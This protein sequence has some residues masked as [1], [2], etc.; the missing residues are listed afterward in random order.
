MKNLFT[1]TDNN[2]EYIL[3]KYHNNQIIYDFKNTLDFLE[4]KGKQLFGDN[5]KIYKDDHP[6]IYKLMIYSIRDQKSC[7]ANNINLQKSILLTGPVGCGKTT[8]MQLMPYITPH[9][10]SYDILSTRNIVFSFNAN[11]YDTI[12]TFSS[13]RACCF[14]DLGAEPTGRHYGHDCNVMAEILIS[15]YELSQFFPPV[16]T[17]S[18]WQRPPMNKKNGS[19]TKSLENQNQVVYKRSKH[20]VN[21]NSQKLTHLTSNLNAQEIEER[22]GERV[23]SRLREMVNVI[24]F[25]ASSIDKR[26]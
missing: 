23:R 4:A 9:F 17:K 19:E 21:P 15:R 8:L 18:S 7:L 26:T 16:K 6:L 10:R 3:G 13:K 14:D 11:G 12:N 2:T 20:S 1:I 22:Y 24:A 25:P 5:F